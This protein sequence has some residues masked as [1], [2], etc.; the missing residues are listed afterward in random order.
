[1]H[2]FYPCLLLCLL[3]YH[4][5]YYSLVELGR[6]YIDV[7]AEDTWQKSVPSPKFCCEAE[8]ALKI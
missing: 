4:H 5:L 6:D 3:L 7:G 8:I 2:I 1:M